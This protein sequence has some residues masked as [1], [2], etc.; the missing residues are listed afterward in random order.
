MA[1]CFASSWRTICRSAKGLRASL[2]RAPPAAPVILDGEMY[3]VRKALCAI[4]GGR[5]ALAAQPARVV[6]C[7]IS[8]VP[9][10]DP[11]TIGSGPT[12]PEVS[13]VATHNVVRTSTA[14]SSGGP[15]RTRSD[16]IDA[17]RSAPARSAERR[18]PPLRCPSA[19]AARREH[20]RRAGDADRSRGAAPPGRPGIRRAGAGRLAAI[21]TGAGT[22]NLPGMSNVLRAL[23]FE[24][25]SPGLAN[26]Q[27]YLDFP[28]LQQSEIV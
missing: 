24:A 17:K 7:L 15:T 9:G 27:H 25:D 19:S 8:D 18:R 6:T 12:I 14:Q 23:V 22:H 2:R 10:G 1:R 28:H 13:D 20:R 4:K 5:L 16:D 21:G 11:A 3:R 26:E